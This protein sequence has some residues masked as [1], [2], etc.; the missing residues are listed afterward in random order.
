[1]GPYR[2][3]AAFDLH[4]D[5]IVDTHEVPDMGEETGADEHL[6]TTSLGL[7]ACA[8]LT[9]S[10]TTVYSMRLR[11]IPAPSPGGFPSLA[12]PRHVLQS[13][14]IVLQHSLGISRVNTHARH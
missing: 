1:M 10:P 6:A 11:I 12:R 2:L 4:L 13:D 8:T 3:L 9:I 7:Q 5:R 14:A